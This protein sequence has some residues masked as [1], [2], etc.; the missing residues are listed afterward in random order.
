MF[1]TLWF[2]LFVVLAGGCWYWNWHGFKKHVTEAKSQRG[3]DLTD[4][5]GDFY[6]IGAALSI[7]S[8]VASLVLAALFMWC[9]WFPIL[10]GLLGFGGYKAYKALDSKLD[11]VGK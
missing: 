9:W 4:K 2:V 6:G 5:K 10:L 1:L 3:F 7:C 11:A 8:L